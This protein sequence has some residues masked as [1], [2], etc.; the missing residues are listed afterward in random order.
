MHDFI[1]HISLFEALPCT[2]Y[3]WQSQSDNQQPEDLSLTQIINNKLCAVQPGRSVLESQRF[4]T[5]IT[6]QW[7]RVSMWRLA[8]G[9]KPTPAYNRGFLLP[10]SL[11]VEAGKLIMGSLDSVG[12]RSKDCHGI[13]MVC[14]L[15]CSLSFTLSFTLSL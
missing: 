12:S 10:L 14:V 9:K 5:L 6:Q 7:L 4:D 11:P 3:E 15:L 2:L 13:G 1:N 8:F